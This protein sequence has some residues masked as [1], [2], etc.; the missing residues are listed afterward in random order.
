MPPCLTCNG[1]WNLTP[2][3]WRRSY[4]WA[5][6]LETSMDAGSSLRPAFF[7][8][9]L[10]L[11]GAALPQTCGTW[12]RRGPCRELA[13]HCLCREA[14]QL[15]ARPFRQTSAAKPSAHGQDLRE[16]PPPLARCWA[17]G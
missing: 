5:E 6:L 15:L 16:S 17:D 3:F 8:S 7:S 10:P 9:P 14:W 12:S 13:E 1:W 4:C 11:P 2:C